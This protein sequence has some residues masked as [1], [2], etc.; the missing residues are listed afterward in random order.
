MR[1][2]VSFFYSRKGEQEA[3]LCLWLALRIFALVGVLFFSLSIVVVARSQGGKR[4][5]RKG[6]AIDSRFISR[7]SLQVLIRAMM[8]KSSSLVG[9]VGER[10]SD[11]VPG[12]AQDRVLW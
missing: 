1:N 2:I 8:A 9:G 4:E 10:F 5:G 7:L 3:V 6:E 12:W 11:R